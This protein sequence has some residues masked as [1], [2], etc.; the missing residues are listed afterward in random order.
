MY[1]LTNGSSWAYDL[2]STPYN[3][4]TKDSTASLRPDTVQLSITAVV[5][6]DTVLAP[7]GFPGS[8][9]V[10]VAIVQQSSIQL[11][12][13]VPTPRLVAYQ[14]Y[15]LG[16]PALYLHGYRSGAAGSL[17]KTSGRTSPIFLNGKV[18]SDQRRCVEALVG[19]MSLAPLD[20][21]VREIPPKE[22][23]RFPLSTGT[24]WTFRQIGAPFR[25]D[26]QVMAQT[27]IAVGGASYDCAV[28]QYFYD[29]DNN[30]VWDTNISVVDLVS[31]KGLLKR[32][33]DVK[34]LVATSSASPADTVAVFDIREEYVATAVAV[35]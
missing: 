9:S 26:K 30:G 20:S 13:V 8:S 27:A 17:P 7:G 21:I 6:G 28:V 10:L 14:F 15:S 34:D 11:R 16:Q 25:I 35:R 12:P 5:M 29:I 32:T 24:R 23:L 2:L 4:R 33:I 3:F 18:F 1:P 22:V 19:L 31:A